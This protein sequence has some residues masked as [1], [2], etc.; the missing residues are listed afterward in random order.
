MLGTLGVGAD[1]GV[2]AILNVVGDGFFQFLPIALAV[3]AA[4]RFKLNQ[5]VGMAVAA[6]FLHPAIGELASGEILYT[7]FSGTPFE[8]NVFFTLQKREW[9]ST[10]VT[11]KISPYWEKWVS[12]RFA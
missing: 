11:K 4:A 5:F 6:A 1:N 3:T 2:Y 8:S 9:I 10:I 7:L 12:R